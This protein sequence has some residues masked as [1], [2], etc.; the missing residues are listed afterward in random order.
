MSVLVTGGAGYIGSVVVEAL[1]KA[2]EKVVVLDNLSTGHLDAVHGAAHFYRGDCDNTSVLDTILKLHGVT[3]CIHMA[4]VIN[5]AESI[6]KPYRYFD[7]N[8]RQSADL[9][10]RL[11]GWGVTSFVYSSSC[12]AHEPTSPYGWTKATVEQLLYYLRDAVGT[13]HV[14]LRYHNAAGATAT[15]GE[16]HT[17]ETHLIPKVLAVAAGEAPYVEIF[18]NDYSLHG[19]G[20]AVRD[21]IHV[22]DLARAHLDALRVVRGGSELTI[23]LGSGCPASVLDVIREAEEVTGKRIPVVFSER[24]RGDKPHLVADSRHASKLL[25]WK[26]EHDLRSILQSAW[27]WKLEHEREWRT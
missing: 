15:L 19:D 5:T 14:I 4:G 3:E 9:F 27:K 18:G 1:I 16:F 17:P 20:T 13:S 24:R 11:I 21:Y 25:T 7:Q 2:G 26:A 22:S 8:V 10:T 23:S 6:S 12:A